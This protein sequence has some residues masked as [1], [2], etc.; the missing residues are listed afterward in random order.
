MSDPGRI[1][2]IGAGL[3]GATAAATLRERGY[4]GEVV[5]LGAENHR[6]YELPPLSKAVLLGDADEPDWVRDEGFYRENDVDL[7]LG[8][9]AVRVDPGARLVVDDKGG[10][11]TYDRLLLATGSQPRLLPGAPPQV[12]TLRTIDDSLA[13]RDAFSKSPRV[14]I[15][16]AGWIGTEAA[17]AARRHGADVT[18]V[19]QVS[20]PLLSVLGP[21]IGAV[22]QE[23]HSEN[24]VHWR[25][26]TGVDEM[27]PDQV[28]L[29]DGTVLP[30]DLVLVAVGVAPR[31]DLAHAAGLD[32]AD[33]GGIAVD[34]T[35][36]TSA[37]HVYAA[38]DIASQFHPRYSKRVRVEHWANAKNQGAHV[39]GSLLGDDEPY[40]RAPYFFSDQY[41]LGCEYRGLAN[42]DSHQ[43]VVRGDLGK[44]EF[45]AFWTHQGKVTAAMN[46]NIWDAG[47]ALKA[48]VEEDVPVTPEQL[49]ESE[50]SSLV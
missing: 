5:V 16:G 20:A 41:S 38:G 12:H 10:E 3:G 33:D 30:A 1:V 27:T 7:R 22:F 9:T 47:D 6:P 4:P 2:I 50:L 26:G 45:I 42:V 17:A 31:V 25:L 43:L 28:R 46:V 32:I 15:I 34:P 35:L 44:R 8:T 39:A 23:L 48:L 29:S 19:D 11:H 37:P 36:R 14:V 18:V 13:L 21:E 24:G 49:R 40:L